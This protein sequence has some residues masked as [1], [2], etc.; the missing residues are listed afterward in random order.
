MIETWSPWKADRPY[1]GAPALA[2][3][4]RQKDHVDGLLGTTLSPAMRIVLRAY[5]QELA[6]EIAAHN[7]NSLAGERQP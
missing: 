6:A 7:D 5:E 3:A 2:E 4:V 1:T